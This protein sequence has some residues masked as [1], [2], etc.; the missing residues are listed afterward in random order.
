MTAD[1]ESAVYIGRRDCGCIRAA[2]VDTPDERAAVARGTAKMIRDG[3]AVER[4][5]AESARTQRWVCAAHREE[6]AR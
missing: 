4:V 5:S 3:L 1:T 2:V 6:R